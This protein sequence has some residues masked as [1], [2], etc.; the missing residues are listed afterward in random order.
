[1][2]RDLCLLV[3]KIDAC[4]NDCMLYW[5]DDIDLDYYKFCGEARYKLIR[6]R[7]CNST[8]TPYAILSDCRANDV[9]CLS[10]DREGIHV[11]SI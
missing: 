1:M 6:E 11:L 8:K 5:K 2:I 3:E 10:S 7:N 9:V 4:K